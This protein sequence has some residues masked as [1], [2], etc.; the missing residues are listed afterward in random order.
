[1]EAEF[2]ELLKNKTDLSRQISLDKKILALTK[3]LVW[4]SKEFKD[5]EK[6]ITIIEKK[7]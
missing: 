7:I 6:L 4:N 3:R 2:K 1:M 5:A